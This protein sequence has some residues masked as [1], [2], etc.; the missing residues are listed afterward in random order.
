MPPSKEIPE[1]VLI[2]PECLKNRFSV[3]KRVHFLLK[4]ETFFSGL[5]ENRNPVLCD[6]LLI[7]KIL[8]YTDRCDILEIPGSPSK[9]FSAGC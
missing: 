7:L 1:A 6:G 2:D 3:L 4:A 5:P 8:V 9:E